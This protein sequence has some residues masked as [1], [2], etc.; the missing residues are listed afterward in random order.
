MTNY[1]LYNQVCFA[2]SRLVTE[3]YSTSFSKA[4]ELYAPHIRKHI[5][6]I[7]G[8]VRF[9]DEIV[10]TFHSFEKKQL[11][12][13]FVNEYHKT[14]EQNISLNPILQSFCTT[15]KQFKIEQELVDAFLHSMY[16]DLGDMSSLTQEEYSNY[17]Y[18]SAEVVGLM[19]LRIFVEGNEAEY[20][21]LKSYARDFGSALQK[22]NFLRDIR[23]DYHQ[24]GRV[25]FPSVD[26][27]NFT[28]EE[29]QEIENDIEQEF[30]SAWVGIRQLPAHSKYAVELAYLYYTGLLKNIQKTSVAHIL[31][32]RIRVSNTEK[33]WMYARVYTKHKLNNFFQ[34]KNL[35]N[36][37]Q[38]EELALDLATEQ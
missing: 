5:Y 32:N 23:A 25:Y 7:Y 28:E 1:N 17:I 2:T 33:K 6:N 36:T 13:S 16:M 21:R 10:D 31:K 14:L 37:Q 22:V 29:K 12:D 27:K 20:N 30:N 35:G 26:F 19:C 34:N 11:L 9:A 8:F 4:T 3:K 18:G 15:Q 24:L 38:Q